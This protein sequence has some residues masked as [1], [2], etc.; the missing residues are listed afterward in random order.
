VAPQPAFLLAYLG[1]QTG[2]REVTK[3]G[4]DVA[5]TRTPLDPL[6][7]LLRKVWLAEK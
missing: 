6:L 7:P 5:Q 4:L 2:S 1:Y 3:Y